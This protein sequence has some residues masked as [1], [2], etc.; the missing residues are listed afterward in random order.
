MCEREPDDQDDAEHQTHTGE[1][2]ERLQ[3]VRRSPDDEPGDQSDG[4]DLRVVVPSRQGHP[5]HEVHELERQGQY[6]GHTPA[7]PPERRDA[8]DEH[9]RDRER[10]AQ[11]R[12]EPRQEREAVTPVERSVV[13][14]EQ[15][16]DEPEEERA[17][18]ADERRPHDVLVTGAEEHEQRRRDGRRPGPHAGAAHEHAQEQRGTEM[19]AQQQ[20]P[21]RDIGAQPEESP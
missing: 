16:L 18:E 8:D 21:V 15:Q 5:P 13:I 2:T 14:C 10:R 20:Q 6:R 3:G 12:R 19:Q 11:H 7:A 4:C 1:L 9:H 17:S